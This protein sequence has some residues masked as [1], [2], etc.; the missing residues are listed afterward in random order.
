M[1]SKGSIH[2]HNSSLLTHH[3][4]SVLPELWGEK[5]GIGF[6]GKTLRLQNLTYLSRNENFYTYAPTWLWDYS[7]NSPQEW[8]FP[9]PFMLEQVKSKS[10]FQAEEELLFQ[11]KVSQFWQL[12]RPLCKRDW[13]WDKDGSAMGG[14]TPYQNC[15]VMY[16][17]C[18]C[19]EQTWGGIVNVPLHLFVLMWPYWIHLSIPF[20]FVSLIGLLKRSDW[21]YLCGLWGL[22]LWP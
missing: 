4:R 22:R 7:N 17:S 3:N 13:C 14:V 5:W 11:E 10:W 21:V 20:T 8:K 15:L 2:P 19:L 16:T 9:G 18:F 1:P 12:V 6:V